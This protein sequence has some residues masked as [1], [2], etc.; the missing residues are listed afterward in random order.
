M[1][2]LYLGGLY[3]NG[4]PY[5]EEF[6]VIDTHIAEIAEPHGTTEVVAAATHTFAATEKTLMVSYTATGICT[7]T[8]PSAEIA[9]AGREFEIKDSGLN[10]LVYG[11]VIETEGAE[12]IEGETSAEIDVNGGCLQLKSDGTNLLDMNR[13]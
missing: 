13:R 3:L 9:K 5:S 8:I 1:G 7:V 6:V 10:A 4:V 12:T 11:I 2:G